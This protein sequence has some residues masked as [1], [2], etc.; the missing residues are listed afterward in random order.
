MV[1]QKSEMILSPTSEISLDAGLE[2]G[3]FMGLD[4]I[5]TATN[6]GTDDYSET[7]VQI[8]G[9]DEADIIKT[10]GKYIYALVKNDLYIV[11]AY[12]AEQT[13]V[14]TKIAFKDRP[15]D[16]YISEDRLVVFGRNNQ[17]YNTKN[18]KSFRR[19]GNYTFFKIF[20]ISNPK[21]PKQ[22]KDLDFEGN[23]A[24]SRMIGDYI[25]FVT[26]NYN[27]YYIE[28]EPVLPRILDSG[29][30]ISNF[31]PEIYYFD[32]P[33]QSHNFTT[34]TAINI[35]DTDKDI[36]GDVYLMSSNQNMFVSMNN[37]YIT[38]TKYISEY[39]LIMAVTKDIIYPMLSQ[40]DQEKISK[41]ESV[42]NYILNQSEKMNKIGLIIQNYQ[43]SLTEDELDNLEDELEVAFKKKYKDISKEM[44]KTVIHKIGI[45]N[46]KM[47]YKTFGEVTG[48]VLNQFSM[49]ESNGYFRI[50]TTKNRTWSHWLEDDEEQESYSN[51]YVLDEN[52]KLVGSV[53]ELAK[54]ERIYSVRFMQNRA[55]LVTFQ[56]I[57]PLFVIDL[58]NP[59]NPNVLGELKIPG[60]SNYLHPYDDNLLIGIGKDTKINE[61]N[62]VVTLGVKL[63]LFDVSNIGNPTEIDN[64]VLG[65][66]GSNS[67]A[68]SDHK[69]FLFSKEKNLLAI[70]ITLRE[71]REG[72]GYGK[73][74]FIGAAVFHIDENGFELKGK[75]D[76]SD[77]G[78]ESKSDSWRGYNYYDNTVKRS[79]YLDDNL[80]T[81][82][83]RYLKINKIEN[84]DEVKN[85]ELK[86]LRSGDD[87]DFDVI[88]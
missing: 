64:Y 15:Q 23:Y 50:A 11:D 68:L 71:S 74:D 88:N 39:Q 38:Y 56:Q 9:V 10:D 60:F 59:K 65:N 46:D 62:R 32:I 40:N 6:Q 52:M 28:G 47:E 85:V 42:E 35:K 17:I 57:D 24:N 61:Y 79:L 2:Q 19:R 45:N 26:S 20:D 21:N 63:S 44:E 5:E 58:S 13:E 16:I 73:I 69:A 22:L 34:I 4:D 8:K 80:Y 67:I 7:N 27:Y 66:S 25:Y 82:S 18:Y 72:R 12:P 75:I 41:I 54:G 86:K 43:M 33:Y 49:E 77:N 51:L 37:I 30:A 83:N 48:Y 31:S 84:L 76:H 78:R 87:D 14:L 55:Y 29:D 70:P 3:S 81:F 53:E 36:T 1:R